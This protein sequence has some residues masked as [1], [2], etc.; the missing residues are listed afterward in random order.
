MLD[1]SM[2]SRARRNLARRSQFA[3]CAVA[4]LSTKPEIASSLRSSQ[5][6]AEGSNAP[7]KD[8]PCVIASEAKQSQFPACADAC[9]STKPEIASS[10]TLFANIFFNTI[11]IQPYAFPSAC[12][13]VFIE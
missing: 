9:F 12:R 2:S 8:T 1:T 4:C 3:A 5:R 6:Y 10:L 11:L 7:C 13:I